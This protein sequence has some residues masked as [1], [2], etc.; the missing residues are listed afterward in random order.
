MIYFDEGLPCMRINQILYPI[1][2]CIYLKKKHVDLS[3]LMT[4]VVYIPV[5]VLIHIKWRFSFVNYCIVIVNDYCLTLNQQF[6]GYIIARTSEFSMKWWWGSLCTRSTRLDEFLLENLLQRDNKDFRLLF[7]RIQ[8]HI[9]GVMVNML[10]LSAVHRGFEPRSS[11]SITSK[12][13]LVLVHI[14]FWVYIAEKWHSNTVIMVVLKF[15]Q[16]ILI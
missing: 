14:E 9:G 1:K 6:F 11:V 5:N 10:T 16:L 4:L 8:N 7:I 12:C 3:C 13:S 15:I 2:F